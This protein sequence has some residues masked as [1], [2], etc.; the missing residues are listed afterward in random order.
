MYAICQF[1][2]GKESHT[3]AVDNKKNVK[4]YRYQ[5]IGGSCIPKN[6]NL[7]VDT[8]LLRQPGVSEDLIKIN[9]FASDKLV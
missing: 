4:N 3:G 5:I 1:L 6:G 9:E 8:D 7:V 2:N